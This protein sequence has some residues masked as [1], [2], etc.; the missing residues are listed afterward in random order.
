MKNSGFG[1]SFLQKGIIQNEDGLA[2]FFVSVFIVHC[3]NENTSTNKYLQLC[4]D[5]GWSQAEL[6]STADE[7]TLYLF[8]SRIYNGYIFF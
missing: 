6:K 5:N 2:K 4:F 7:A 8:P 3:S 1:R